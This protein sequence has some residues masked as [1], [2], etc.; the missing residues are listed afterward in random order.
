[1]AMRTRLKKTL[2]QNPALVN[3]G[4]GL[5]TRRITIFF[6]FN[7]IFDLVEQ[8]SWD[9]WSLNPLSGNQGLTLNVSELMTDIACET[10]WLLKRLTTYYLTGR[11]EIYKGQVQW[12]M[13]NHTY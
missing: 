13:A 6:I 5:N 8:W 1:M 11:L 10:N 3:K 2:V 7:L 12:L 9:C 4:K